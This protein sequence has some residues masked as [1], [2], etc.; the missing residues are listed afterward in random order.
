MVVNDSIAAETIFVDHIFLIVSK[1]NSVS[2]LKS[3]SA[4]N[5]VVTI[6]PLENHVQ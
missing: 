4:Y 2:M 1:R 5:T 6:R 3:S